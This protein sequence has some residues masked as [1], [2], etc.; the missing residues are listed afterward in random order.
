MDLT[1]PPEL[2][3]DEQ[4]EK[5][6]ELQ[7]YEKLRRKGVDRA[8]RA[9]IK[10]AEL[11]GCFQQVVFRNYDGISNVRVRFDEL[12]LKLNDPTI[13]KPGEIYPFVRIIGSNYFKFL[14]KNFCR[15]GIGV[16]DIGS[17]VQQEYTS[18]IRTAHPNHYVE[19]NLVLYFTGILRTRDFVCKNDLAKVSVKI[20]PG[21]KPGLEEL[22][23]VPTG[24]VDAS[25]VCLNDIF[26]VDRSMSSEEIE[27]P[28]GLVDGQVD[29]CLLVSSISG[30]MA[31]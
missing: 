28:G 23:C 3:K 30:L 9:V 2:T 1:V 31:A 12:D 11:L 16:Q 13:G 29:C 17:C 6:S 26:S 25:M 4:R 18:T 14:A 27:A 7:G 8:A 19:T 20:R 24:F 22:W 21:D 5:G 10:Q 15:V